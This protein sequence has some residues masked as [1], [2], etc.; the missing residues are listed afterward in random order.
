VLLVLLVKKKDGTYHFSVDFRNPNAITA[1]SKFLVS[2]F[3]QLMDELAYSSWF[4]IL[5]L[6]AGFHQ[7]LMQPGEE[8]KM[9]FQTHLGLYEFCVMAFGLTGPLAT[10]YLSGHDEHNSCPWSAQICGGLLR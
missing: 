2:V 3:D 1:K 8:Y 7:I 9:A 4:S 6:W 10:R 5:D